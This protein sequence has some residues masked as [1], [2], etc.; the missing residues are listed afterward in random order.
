MHN[1]IPERPDW[2]N[3]Y[4]TDAKGNARIQGRELEGSFLAWLDESPFTGLKENFLL[5]SN[6]PNPFNP[7][8]EIP[9]Y[10]AE[11]QPI[12]LMIYDLLGQ[13]II[14]LADKSYSQGY[15]HLRWNG[16]D[17]HGNEIPGGIYFYQ[18]VTRSGRQVRRMLL[19]K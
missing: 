13:H 6:Y 9:F 19:L 2:V 16:R 8:T 10:L 15:H 11:S 14:T 17:R 3:L 18:I 5:C 12:R 4:L 7:T 1:R